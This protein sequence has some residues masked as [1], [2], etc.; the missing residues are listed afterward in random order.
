MKTRRQRRTIALGSLLADLL[1][2]LA[3][4]ASLRETQRDLPGLTQTAWPFLAALVVAWLSIRAWR[5]PVRVAWTGVLVWAITAALGMVLRAIFQE[6]M[7]ATQL[8]VSSVALGVFVVG[9]RASVWTV[10][11][12]FGAEERVVDDKY[13]R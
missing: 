2:I 3:F 5:A 8:F 10:R 12:L 9:W 7:E 11:A 4:V 1:G 13:R 6:P